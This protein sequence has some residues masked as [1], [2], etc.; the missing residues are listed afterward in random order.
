MLTE[1]KIQGAGGVSSLLPQKY[2]AAQV[3]VGQAY[4]QEM[5][6]SV[7]D[8]EGNIY[9]IGRGNI[10]DDTMM[11][12]KYHADGS[13]VAWMRAVQGTYG[14]WFGGLPVKLAIDSNDFLYAAYRHRRNNATFTAQILKMS[15]VDGSTI[16]NSWD[17]V[18]ERTDYNSL[19]IDANDNIYTNGFFYEGAYYNWVAKYDTSLNRSLSYS[20]RGGNLNGVSVFGQD[21]KTMSNGDVIFA[22]HSYV[23]GYT[24]IIRANP[25]N[26]AVIWSKDFAATQFGNV[27]TID[28][29]DNIYFGVQKNGMGVVKLNSS[30]AVQWALTD[31]NTG[32]SS[33][34]TGV[35]N[36]PSGNV[37]FTYHQTSSSPQQQRIIKLNSSGGFI[38]GRYIENKVYKE[39]RYQPLNDTFALTGQGNTHDGSGQGYNLL[40]FD[41]DGLVIDST[42]PVGGLNVM[43]TFTATM[44]SQSVTAGTAATTTADVSG[45]A[46]GFRSVYNA[47]YTPPYVYIGLLA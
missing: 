8:T 32:T 6:N 47:A 18:S 34:S 26:F 28:D 35:A 45:I 23:N 10:V 15:P 16:L 36:D 39:M 19:H 17:Y 29:S 31:G 22:I 1:S 12:I 30:G 27:L 37:Y 43:G 25:S 11:V 40:V 5:I 14:A 2:I 24:T 42:Q 13:G 44:T 46:H 41:K 7:M 38:W 21:V 20:Y 33:F 9:T 3:G 4:N